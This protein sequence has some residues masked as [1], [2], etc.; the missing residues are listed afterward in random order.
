MSTKEAFSGRPAK[1]PQ[2]L[3]QNI[4]K[5]NFKKISCNIAKILPGK[6]FFFHKYE[7]ITKFTHQITKFVSYLRQ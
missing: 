6:N 1:N 5:K 3:K 4:F 7:K 2:V